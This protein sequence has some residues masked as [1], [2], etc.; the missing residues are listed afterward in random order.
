MG[1]TLI[2]TALAADGVLNWI[3]GVIIL[4][5]GAGATY[6]ASAGHDAEELPEGA[7][8]MTLAQSVIGLTLGLGVLLVSARALVWG[9][10]SLAITLGVPEVI[11]GLTV[12]AIG[13]SLPEVAASVAG[14]MKGQP[15]IAI[16]N[17]VGSNIFNI[18]GVFAVAGLLA[19]VPISQD[20]LTRDFGAMIVMTALIVALAWVRGSLGKTTGVMLLI[21]YLAYTG[22]LIYSTL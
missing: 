13:T 8:Q 11:V 19:E 6:L 1:M 21:A 18:G 5:A 22:I 2:G 9:A 12:V 14:A 17:V 3:D 4:A 20:T 10:S 16:G 7:E 15:G